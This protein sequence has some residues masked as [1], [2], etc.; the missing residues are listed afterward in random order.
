MG[1]FH[2]IVRLHSG[3]TGFSDERIEVTSSE[4]MTDLM[5]RELANAGERCPEEGSVVSGTCSTCG[6]LHRRVR[7]LFEH[8]KKPLKSVRVH[9]Y[10]R[11]DE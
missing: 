5:N 6:E 7:E 1:K 11:Q 8:E 10:L 3:T 2:I 4:L 9:V